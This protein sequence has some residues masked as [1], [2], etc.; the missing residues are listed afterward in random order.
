MVASAE[1]VA[2][3]R[4]LTGPEDTF[5]RLIA[6]Q[7]MHSSRAYRIAWKTDAK[8]SKDLCSRVLARPHV[9]AKIAELRARADM[10]AVM[11]MN[12]RRRLLA[13]TARKAKGTPTHADR[14]R[15]IAEDATLAGERRSDA[16]QVN[17]AVA[18]SLGDILGSL[19]GVSPVE[20][21]PVSV[22]GESLPESSGAALLGDTT[23][24][25]GAAAARQAH[26]L[27]VAGSI[28]APAPNVSAGPLDGAGSTLGEVWEDE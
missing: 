3:G 17:I 27:E 14:I 16:T 10:E 23:M 2:K 26:N 24:Q 22:A 21:V 15:A 18:V 4:T 5:C 20:A 25:G 11:S 6:C 28:P 13:E 12:E 8:S 19:G 9:A 1:P 7:G